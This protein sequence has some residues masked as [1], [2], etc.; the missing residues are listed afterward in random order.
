[1]S[2]TG[3]AAA[4]VD[5]AACAAAIA[6]LGELERELDKI[7]TLKAR[8]VARAAAKAEIRAKPFAD[9]AA[10]LTADVEAYCREHRERLTGGKSKTCKFATG[11]ASWR[12]GKDGVD[13]DPSMAAAVLEKLKRLQGG[14]VR[15][16][17]SID[18]AAVLKALTADQPSPVKR[19]RGI[20]LRKGAESF[21]I[22]PIGAELRT[23]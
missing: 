23:R 3:A 8:L 13:V 15:V 9:E 10:A 11:E 22:K 19:M 21:A 18:A 1:M 16:V 14:F 5:D 6:R 20:T 4:L 12:K 7:A 2:E 17:Y